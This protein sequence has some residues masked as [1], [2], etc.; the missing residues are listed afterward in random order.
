MCYEEKWYCLCSCNKWFGWEME[1]EKI[2]KRIS[3]HQIMIPWEK[4]R[5][6]YKYNRWYDLIRR[7]IKKIKVSTKYF[8]FVGV[9]KSELKG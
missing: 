9:K 6:K 3:W 2:R 4:K 7:E 8:I 1:G 5:E